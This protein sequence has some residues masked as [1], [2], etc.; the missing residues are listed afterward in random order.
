MRMTTADASNYPKFHHYVK[1][2]ISILAN[3]NPVINAI[4]RFSGMTT[5]RTIKNGLQWGNG[6]T[7]KIVPNLVCASSS[8]YGCYSWGG[9]EIEIDQSLVNAY[10]AGTDMRP[11]QRGAMVSVAGVT[12][13]HEL[14]HWADARDG[15]DDPV[16]GD[17][18]NEEGDAFERALYGKVITL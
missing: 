14:T 18:S 13:L 12:L 16:P 3:V 7:I 17:P 11:T 2:E 5:R 15:V 8:A 1:N 10:E 9:N 6:P 4:K